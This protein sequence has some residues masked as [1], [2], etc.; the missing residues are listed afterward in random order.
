VIRF[1]RVAFAHPGG[2]RLFAG[3]EACFPQGRVSAVAG[4]N[5]AGKSTLLR[6]A[7]G[8]LRP[9]AGRCETAGVDPAAVDPLERAKRVAYVPQKAVPPPGWPVCDA[10]ELGD[11][12]HR[13]RPPAPRPLKERL[14]EARRLLGLEEV[15]ERSVDSLSGGEAQRVVLARAL[16][17]DT[18][19]LLLDEP[20]A[21]LD[22]HRQ[23]ELHSLLAELAS[24]GRTV[25][26]ATHDVN[27]PRLCG[28][29]LYLLDRAGS[30]RRLPEGE[31]RQRS[32]LEEV[33]ETTLAP[34][35]LGGVTC[36]FPPPAGPPGVPTGETR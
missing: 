31:A 29:D 21:S 8:L 9:S 7:A 6:L 36:W 3:I 25:L 4:P 27:V 1:E 11:H 10:V 16:V 22:L 12:P 34:C 35:R 28:F 17:Q 32:L 23:V 5:G 33:Y 13:E 14:A 18:P 30:I 24:R 2:R 15:W 19:V 20:A 26:L